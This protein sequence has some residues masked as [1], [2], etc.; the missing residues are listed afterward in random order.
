MRVVVF[1]GVVADDPA[2][3]LEVPDDVG[4]G[5]EDVHA[6]PV[7]DLCGEAALV[8]D[9]DDPTDG[10]AVRLAGRLVVLAEAGRHVDG[11]GT[12]GGVDE[13]GCQDPEGVCAVGEEV[14]QRGVGASDEVGA[15]DGADRLGVC[16]LGLVALH[17]VGPEHVHGAVGVAVQGVGEVGAHGESQ[18]GRQGPGGGRPCQEAH[19]AR[20]AVDGGE[21]E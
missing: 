13:V 17:G 12:L 21:V 9:R 10:D 11:A 8:V 19:G 15:G 2:R 16:Q 14:E 1:V 6:G 4:V 20:I 18:V 5:L 3:L 7:D